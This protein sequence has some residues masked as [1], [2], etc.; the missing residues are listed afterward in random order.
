M[1]GWDD[2]RGGT[3]SQLGGFQRAHERTSE[4]SY[5]RMDGGAYLYLVGGSS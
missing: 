1:I 3:L 4:R 5:G 2:G